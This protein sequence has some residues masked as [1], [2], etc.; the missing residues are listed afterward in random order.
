MKKETKKAVALEYNLERDNAPR[1]TATGKG[2]IADNILKV[3]EKNNV[4]IYEDERLVK[5][6]IQFQVGTEIPEELYEIVAQ[7][8]VFVEGIDKE[9]GMRNY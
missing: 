2:D 3:A 1:I 5:E 7:I 6:L 9:K 4:L 8:L